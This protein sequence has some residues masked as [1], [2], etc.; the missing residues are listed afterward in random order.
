MDLA[1]L[2]LFQALSRKMNWLTARQ[3]VLSRNVANIDTPQYQAKDLRPLDFRSTLAGATARLQPVSTDSKHLSGSL[4]VAPPAQLVKSDEERSINGNTVSVEDEMMK[5]SDTATDYQLMT[6]L[7]KKQLGML[8]AAI[9][10]SN[11]A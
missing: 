5:V 9:G 2:P 6:N 1:N 8:K 11:G 7:Y 3:D 4:P 10:H